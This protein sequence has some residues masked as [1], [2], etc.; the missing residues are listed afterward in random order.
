[1]PMRLKQF[2]CFV[3]VLF[4]DVRRVLAKFVTTLL[5]IFIQRALGLRAGAKSSEN[6][7]TLK[8]TI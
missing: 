2:E 5:Q 3:S 8:A 7:S 6:R 4:H 1:M